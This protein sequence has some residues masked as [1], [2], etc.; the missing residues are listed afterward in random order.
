[1]KRSFW[2]VLA[3]LLSMLLSTMPAQAEATAQIDHWACENVYRSDARYTQR[4]PLTCM[5]K[6]F[7][8]A[9][10]DQ[11]EVVPFCATN[12]KLVL[13]HSSDPASKRVQKIA[14]NWGD[15]P[16]NALRYAKHVGVIAVIDGR[17]MAIPLSQAQA[18]AV[19][20]SLGW[21]VV[22]L[23]SGE[24]ACDMGPDVTHVTRWLGV[25]KPVQVSLH[26]AQQA[27]D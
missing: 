10:P 15:L 26:I 16:K 24:N 13:G 22:T 27:G 17:R 8:V 4:D 14:C 11:G 18:L 2:G 19:C 5:V 20:D 6:Y 9:T 12:G 7:T 1:M 3:L 23:A 25:Y 21:P